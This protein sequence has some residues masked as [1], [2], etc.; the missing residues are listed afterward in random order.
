MILKLE[1]KKL[2]RTGIVLFILAAAAAA[3]L[4]PVINMAARSEMFVH[5]RDTPLNI[6]LDANWQ[7]MAMINL[8]F[9]LC[10]ASLIFHTEFA[11][12]A[13]SKMDALPISAPRMFLGKLTILVL[14][15]GISL[16]IE[17]ASLAFCLARWYGQT[18]FSPEVLILMLKNLAF[19]WALLLP[20]CTLLL[21]IASIFRNMWIS[22]GIGVIGIFT[23]TMIPSF[24]SL[25]AL[26]LFPLA[27]PFQSLGDGALAPGAA[28]LLL[29]ALMETIVFLAG[30]IIFIHL[31][32]R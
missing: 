10:A 8:L 28:R 11:D 17:F 15:A 5:Q 32:R 12:N 21:V 25:K 27:L 31:R 9:L 29:A 14:A 6:L 7:L 1:L 23:A 3:A 4:F 13:A 30:E 19:S 18:L 2:R 16:L 24:S 20:S 22:L 26:T